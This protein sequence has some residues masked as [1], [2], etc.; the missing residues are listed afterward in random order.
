[1]DSSQIFNQYTIIWISLSLS[2]SL[3]LPPPPKKKTQ[4]SVPQAVDMIHI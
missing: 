3:S 2:L 4:P 1:L